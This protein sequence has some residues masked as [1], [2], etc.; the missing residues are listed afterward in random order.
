M[1]KNI[2]SRQRK[3]LL[4]CIAVSLLYL[5]I[6]A[7]DTFTVKPMP[8]ASISNSSAN[9][10]TS[11]GRT[12][13]ILLDSAQYPKVFSPAYMPFTSQ[14]IKRGV[15]GYSRVVG[16]PLSIAG[17]HALFEGKIDSISSIIEDFT[18][19]SAKEDN[20]FRHLTTQGKKV[21]LIGELIA[22]AYRDDAMKT[23]YKP[24]KHYFSEYRKDAADTFEQASKILKN[25][26]WLSH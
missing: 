3:L 4:I 22:P 11:H 21:I 9:K 7:R 23:S 8:M 12:L 15:W 6:A 14:T 5:A 17:D 13:V 1:Q 10:H 18:P 19:V 16:I 25:K 2:L 20:L 26:P 24:V